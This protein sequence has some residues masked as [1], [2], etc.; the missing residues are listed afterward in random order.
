LAYW[1]A[2][3]YWG[4]SNGWPKKGWNYSFF[5]HSLE[6]YPQAYLI[7]SIFSDE[8]LVHIG[9]V[10]NDADTL[11]WNDVVVG[12]KAVS[13][14]WNRESGKKYNIFTYTNADEVEL[15]V[16][17]KSVGIQQNSV[18]VN[19]RNMIFWQNIPYVPGKITAIARKDGKEVA[20]HQLETTGKAVALQIE[21]ENA[22]WKADGMD[23]QYIKV[24]AVDSKGRKVPT[25][26]GEVS[27]EVSGAARLIA[28][29]N[30][31]HSSDDLFNGNKKRLHNGFAMAILRSN[32]TAGTVKL[33]VS[34]IGLKQVEKTL[35]TK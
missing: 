2:I 23:L 20:R 5:N 12:R 24:Y 35:A 4:E 26:T 21:T 9:V 32:Q 18:D 14:H 7:K 22:A 27:F 34:V 8:P 6:P 13:S 29:D 17:G 19:K 1:G 33:K 31:D 28:L 30:G 10:D 3:E 16:N 25:A 11:T 15:L